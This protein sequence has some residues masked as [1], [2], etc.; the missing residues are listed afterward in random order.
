[1][2]EAMT[3]LVTT[4]PQCLLYSAA[5]ALELSVDDV[6]TQLG[7]DGME[8]VSDVPSPHC[9]RGIHI[10]EIQTVAYKIGKLLACIQLVPVSETGAIYVN[11]GMDYAA[12]FLMMIRGKRGILF[13][14][15]PRGIE[16]AVAFSDDVIYDPNGKKYSVGN[17]STREAW[18]VIG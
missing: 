4:K 16:H 18:V 15:S 17:F 11:C 9:Y 10:Q 12:R 7:H 13:G 6:V 5:M 8:K 2:F 1:M 3:H 14:Q